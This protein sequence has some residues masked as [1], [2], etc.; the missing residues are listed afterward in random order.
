MD[1]NM[2]TSAH[3]YN[4]KPLLFSVTGMMIVV[5]LFAAVAYKSVRFGDMFRRDSVSNG[6]TCFMGSFALVGF[7]VLSPPILARHTLP[8]AFSRNLTFHTVVIAHICRLAFFT[9]FVRLTAILALMFKPIFGSAVIVK[10]RN[11]LSFLAFVA[12]FCYD[13]FNHF[14]LLYRRFRSEPLQ[15]QY[16]CGSFYYSTLLGG[17]K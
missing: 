13:L 7:L 8:V 16:L 3:R 2:T 5:C 10:I 14:R 17:V 12:D 4:S 11:L 6:V 9:V 15:A 1:G